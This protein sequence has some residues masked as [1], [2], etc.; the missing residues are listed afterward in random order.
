M[1]AYNAA[2]LKAV[3]ELADEVAGKGGGCCPAVTEAVRIRGGVVVIDG[4]EYVRAGIC[5]DV[6][7]EV[8]DRYAATLA[9]M[10]DN[11]NLP[12]EEA[13]RLDHEIADIAAEVRAI[14]PFGGD[15]APG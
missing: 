5:R 12:P 1:D 7:D 2:I 6:V 10:M 4:I 15:G 13:E 8:T 3:S 14:W 9:R 11:S